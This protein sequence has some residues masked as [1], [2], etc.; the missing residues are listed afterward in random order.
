MWE[1]LSGKA[2]IM[3]RPSKSSQDQDWAQQALEMNGSGFKSGYATTSRVQLGK[4]PN[5]SETRLSHLHNSLIYQ[6]GAV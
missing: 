5:L 1:N 4:L 3:G 2:W 6:G